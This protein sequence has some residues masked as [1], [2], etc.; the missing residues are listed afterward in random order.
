MRKLTEI[1]KITNYKFHS[2]ENA[3][4]YAFDQL[5]IKLTQLNDVKKGFPT[6]TSEL[7][8]LNKDQNSIDDYLNAII[9]HLPDALE[10]ISQHANINQEILSLCEMAII[11]LFKNLEIAMKRAI[12][13]AYPQANTRDFFNWKDLNNFLS[14]KNIKASEIKGFKEFE[15]LRKVNN[16]LKHGELISTEVKA[17]LEFKETEIFDFPPLVDFYFRVRDKC[18]L[19]LSGIGDAIIQDLYYFSEERL[20]IIAESYR[21]R[22]DAATIET[23]IKLL[24]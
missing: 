15:E 10:H 12:K 8:K 3:S 2:F 14:S 5:T 16:N 9:S 20:E 22:M 11:Y 23:F 17:I 4:N 13:T 21:E 18:E 1:Q 19:F 6:L 24:R 7:E